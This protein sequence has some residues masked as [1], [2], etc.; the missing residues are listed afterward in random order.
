[1]LYLCHTLEYTFFRDKSSVIFKC[2]RA[3]QV[4]RK[5]DRENQL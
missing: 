2:K 3:Q 4:S 1:M 5:S